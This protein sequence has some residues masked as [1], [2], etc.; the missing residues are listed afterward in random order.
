MTD[1]HLPCHKPVPLSILQPIK[2]PSNP[3]RPRQ[4]HPF[5]SVRCRVPA[6][7]GSH[8]QLERLQTRD[9]LNELEARARIDAQWTLEQKGQ[10]A[11]QLI[12]NSTDVK[13]WKEHVQ[14]LL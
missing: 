6:K 2:A 4:L 5:Q 11:D 8:Q 10:L 1:S 7:T 3:N 13:Q 14:R 12:G 9:Q